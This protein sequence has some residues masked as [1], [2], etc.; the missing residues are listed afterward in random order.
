[1]DNEKFDTSMV[2]ELAA[3]DQLTEEDEKYIEERKR[4]VGAQE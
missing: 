3:A 4:R 1:M 2:D